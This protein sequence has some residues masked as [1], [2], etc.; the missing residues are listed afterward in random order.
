MSNELNNHLTSNSVSG[1]STPAILPG[2]DTTLEGITLSQPVRLL[3][4]SPDAESREHI[5]SICLIHPDLDLTICETL[6][7]AV[8][9]TFIQSIDVM[10]LELDHS[11][12]HGLDAMRWL[13]QRR[14]EDAPS[15]IAFSANPSTNDIKAALDC[16]FEDYLNK[17]LELSA[18]WSAIGT[19]V[20]NRRQAR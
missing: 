4:A 17:P 2:P 9:S 18:F 13:N 12:R 3:F 10:M 16:G 15:C 1:P 20:S 6:Q 19:S 14:H 11:D 5:N 8:M 7:D